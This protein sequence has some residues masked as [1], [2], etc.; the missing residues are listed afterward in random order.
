MTIMI[1]FDHHDHDVPPAGICVRSHHCLFHSLHCVRIWFHDDDYRPCFADYDVRVSS[2]SWWWLCE[3]RP[4][5]SLV[6]TTR[7]VFIP[8]TNLKDKITV[9]T[10]LWLAV[11][12]IFIQTLTMNHHHHRHHHHNCHH[13]HHHHHHSTTTCS[14]VRQGPWTPQRPSH[15]PVPGSS[16]L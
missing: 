4:L 15:S 13:H 14:R 1:I 9:V 12:V 16:H 8:I 5:W 3:T 11:I 7:A 10:L 6:F 2:L